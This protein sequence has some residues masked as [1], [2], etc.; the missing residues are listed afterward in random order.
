[1]RFVL[2]ADHVDLPARGQLAADLASGLS[3]S[4]PSGWPD[5]T[6]LYMAAS[7]TSTVTLSDPV[8]SRFGRILTTGDLDE[9]AFATAV[10]EVLAAAAEPRREMAA[11]RLQ[12]A[13]A[14]AKQRGALC[15]R[16]AAMAA[17]RELQG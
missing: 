9:A 1:M 13:V 8:A 2:V 5:N 11:D 10:Q 7:A 4:G 12:A 16:A 15:V 6:L 3:G 14:W 17:R